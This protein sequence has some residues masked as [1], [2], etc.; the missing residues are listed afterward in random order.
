MAVQVIC[1]EAKR[2]KSSRNG[3]ARMIPYKKER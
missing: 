2:S 1:A 3:I